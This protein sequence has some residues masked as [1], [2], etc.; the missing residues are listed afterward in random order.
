MYV[1]IFNRV[2]QEKLRQKTWTLGMMITSSFTLGLEGVCQIV[3]G[4]TPRMKD[5]FSSTQ[6][7]EET[8]GICLGKCHQTNLG[9]RSILNLLEFL[10]RYINYSF[11][12]MCIFT[13]LCVLELDLMSNLVV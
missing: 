9:N 13:L 12:E 6:M 11:F 7:M 1:F 4:E 5:W 8:L 10:K 3:T 2:G